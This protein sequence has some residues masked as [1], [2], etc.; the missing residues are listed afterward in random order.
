MARGI[1]KNGLNVSHIVGRGKGAVKKTKGRTGEKRVR[2]IREENAF[3][4]MRVN[5]GRW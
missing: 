3:G 1:R 4:T 5:D 2:G